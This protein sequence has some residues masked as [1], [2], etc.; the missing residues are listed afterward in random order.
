MD[1]TN[2][3]MRGATAARRLAPRGRHWLMVTLITV[4][5]LFVAGCRSVP[6]YW[7]EI[8]IG[9]DRLYVSETNGQVFALDPAT[10]DILWSYPQIQRSGG[11]FLSGCSAQAPSDGPFYAAPAVSDELVYLSSAGE[12]TTSLFR[13]SENTAGLRAL[14]TLGTLQWAF[15]GTEARA[16]ASPV[17]SGS[18]VYLAS[19]DHNVYAID[20]ETRDLRWA[21]E[22]GNWVWANPVVSE[23]TVYVASMDRVLYA[24]DAAS[25]AEIW[26]FDRAT[27]ALPAAPAL[28][29]G[30]LYLG[31]LNGWVYA[32]DATAG[33]LLWE[34]QVSEGIWATLQIAQGTAFFGTLGGRVYA[35]DAENGTTVWEREVGGE[36]RGMPVYIDGAVY[37]GCEDG[38]L[39][40]FD[41]LDGTERPSPLGAT[42][43]NASIYSSPVY[44]GQRLYV[45][46]TNGEVLALDPERSAILWRTNP[47]AAGEEGR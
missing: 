19:S 39:Y 38:R 9:P 24:I 34:A 17:L 5:A 4:A 43:E 22:T 44:D 31:S 12:L 33:D 10:G 47:L 26:R 36:V 40:A 28:V 21:F 30:V 27:S 46:A 3:E 20:V 37:F 45:V 35:L 29:D 2:S 8:A 15:R 42:V 32:V 25:G 23:D 11:G 13:R 1:T 16:V 18:I 7:P 14:N 41:A 6:P